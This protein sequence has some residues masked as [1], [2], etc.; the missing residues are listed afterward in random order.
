RLFQIDGH[1]ID[2]PCELIVALGVVGGHGSV[3]VHSHIR[4]FSSEKKRNS[5]LDSAASG[6]LPIDQDSA[7][8]TRARFSPVVGEIVSDSDATS[9]QALGRAYG[10]DVA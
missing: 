3:K 1:F 4:R 2:F 10:G 9:R 5:A 7:C 8:T 6:F